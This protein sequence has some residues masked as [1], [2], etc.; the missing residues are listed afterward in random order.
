MPR[1]GRA[2]PAPCS[3]F[4]LV[5]LLMARPQHGDSLLPSQ[6]FLRLLLL[7]LG[8]LPSPTSATCDEPPTYSH[9]ELIGNAKTTYDVGERVEYRCKPGYQR[10]PSEAIFT[11]CGADD[12]WPPL[13]DDACYKK[14]CTLPQDPLNGHVNFLNESY[15]LGTQV[16]FICNN[17]FYLIGNE[18]L[19]CLLSGSDVQ[20]SS[21]APEC[22]KSLCRPPPNIPNGGYSSKK[23]VF[24]YLEVVTYTCND[25]PGGDKFSLI[26][27]ATLHCAGRGVWSSDPPECKVVRCP[28]PAIRNGRQTSGFRAKHFYQA[29]VTFECLDGFFLHGQVMAV[30]EANGTWQPPLP[31]CLQE[32]PRLTTNIPESRGAEPTSSGSSGAGPNLPKSSAGRLHREHL[33]GWVVGPTVAFLLQ[34][35]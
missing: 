11:V 20:W 25:N 33:G 23:V 21:E 15:E 3:Q 10:S 34:E 29:R 35:H 17:G 7:G 16:Q 28:H 31:R 14:S 8:V 1:V 12:N 27:E 9:M 2:C 19:H 4:V 24:E 5:L 6:G 26:G 18:I 32:P 22:E 13:S 30:C